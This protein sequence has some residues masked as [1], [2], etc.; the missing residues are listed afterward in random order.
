MNIVEPPKISV[1]LPVYNAEK[2][3]KQAIISILNQSFTDFELIIINDGSTDNSLNVITSIADERI[4]VINQE[5]KGLI[6][7]LNGGIDISQGEYIA[8]MDA[9]DIALPSRFEAQLKLFNGNE[10]LGICG[11]STE[12]FGALSNQKIRSNN[13]QFLKS[14]LLFGPPFAHP[15]VMIKRKTLIENN[16]RYDKDFTHCEDFA[17]WSALKPYCEF[18]NVVEVQLKYRVH[19][20]QITNQF[21]DTVLDAH[22]II[23]R[24]NLECLHL[25]ISKNDFLAYMAKQK[26]KVGFKALL[27]I[28]VSIIEANN[29]YKKFDDEQLLNVISEKT[30]TQLINFY[31][32]TGF[33]HILIYHRPVL[34]NMPFFSTLMF[35]TKRSAVDIY[36]KLFK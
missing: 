21:S 8:R 17:M 6:A 12:N 36:K 31:G 24:K 13:D 16:I 33:I 34:K 2:Y 35:S 5:N 30:T 11:T 7:S 29:T 27:G 28:Y 32:I 1:I 9:D 23:C 4:R 10:E 19:P 20:G 22:F 15:S 25:T 14:Y 18:S 26:H 3:I